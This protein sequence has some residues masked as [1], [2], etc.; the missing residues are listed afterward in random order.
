MSAKLLPYLVVDGAPPGPKLELARPLSRGALFESRDQPCGVQAV[1][2]PEGQVDRIV[3]ALLLDQVAK[4]QPLEL[5]PPRGGESI[6]HPLG[7]IADPAHPLP[8]NEARLL[9][10]AEGVVQRAEAEL[11]VARHPPLLEPL[12]QLIAMQRTVGEQAKHHQRGRH[13]MTPYII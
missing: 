8:G 9:R 12:L 2:Q 7:P 4:H 6:D 3:L 13:E 11:R 1:S 5:L 10:S